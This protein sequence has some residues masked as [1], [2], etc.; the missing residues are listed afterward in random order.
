[1]APT[2]TQVL[3]N[4]REHTYGSPTNVPFS[5]SHNLFLPDCH[6]VGGM[7]G[8]SDLV[9]EMIL[10][11]Y[12]HRLCSTKFSRDD[13]FMQSTEY[14][15]T[16]CERETTEA[17]RG[18]R[19]LHERRKQL[20]FKA[21]YRKICLTNKIDFHSHLWRIIWKLCLDVCY[22][23]G[24]VLEIELFSAR[25]VHPVTSEACRSKSLTWRSFQPF[26]Y[27]VI[28]RIH[29]WQRKINVRVNRCWIWYWLS[30]CNLEKA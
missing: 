30:L 12:R 28:K 20:C 14:K 8:F 18:R 26:G 15:S 27:F 2:Q 4:I 24:S 13:A 23:K 25:S 21:W 22:W 1:M 3:P 7:D 6:M 16:K 19:Q 10:S 29:I 17:S 5:P 11:C 9:K